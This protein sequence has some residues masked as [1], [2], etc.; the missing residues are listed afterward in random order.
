MNNRW[1]FQLDDLRTADNLRQPFYR[2]NGRIDFLTAKRDVYKRQV[3]A[4]AKEGAIVYMAARNLERASQRTEEL[5]AMGYRVRTVYNDA[6]DLESYRTMIEE[7]VKLEGRIDVLVNNFGTS[8]PKTDLD[9]EHTRWEDFQATVDINLASVFVSSQAVIPHMKKQGGGSIVNISSIGGLTPDI[10]RIG[11]AVSKDAI[12]YLSK[13]IAVQTARSNIRVN[14]VCPGQT[15]TDAVMNNMSKEFQDFFLR[16]TPIQ[17]MGKPEEIAAAV[18]YFASDDA[19]YTTGQ[20]MA[21]HGGFGLPTP[22]Y[23]DMIDLSADRKH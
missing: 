1:D 16:H 9:I 13:N 22:V 21:V 19:A 5:N 23:A 12:I 17:R 14:V 20:V 7:V 11:Y 8:D 3:Q 2:L 18:V 6:T 4:C 15:A 10:A